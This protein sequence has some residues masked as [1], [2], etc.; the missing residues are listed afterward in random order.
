[1]IV[2]SPLVLAAGSGALSFGQ[3]MLGNQAK[4]QEHVNQQAQREASSEFASWSSSQQAQQTDLNNQ[5]SYWQQQVNYGQEVVYANQLRNF[6]LARSI[7]Q[8]E[9]VAQ[10]RAGAGANF[11]QASE[12]TSEAFSQQSMSDAVS[13]MQ[14]KQQALRAQAT[15]AAGLNA[16][17]SS[18]RYLNDYARQSGDMASLQMMNQKFR[19]RQYTRDQAGNISQYL[20]QY[21]SQQLYAMQDIQ[22]PIA[23]FAPLPTLVNPAGPSFVGAAPSASTA[24]LGSALGAVGAGINTATALKKY[25]NSGKS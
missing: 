20:N 18:D 17:A 12:A 25:T 19:D 22:D 8:A 2:I 6:E 21:N 15:T 14:Y 5:Y 23:P 16:G 13:L 11:M 1:M 3:S 4:R 10:A 9:L 24:F 7:D